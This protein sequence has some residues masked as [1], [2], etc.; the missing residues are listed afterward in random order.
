MQDFSYYW[1]FIVSVGSFA[2]VC[3]VLLR[4][5]LRLVRRDPKEK[6]AEDVR[7]R[8]RILR[9]FLLAVTLALTTLTTLSAQ[10]F[11]VT[12]SNTVPVRDSAEHF[13]QIKRAALH[14]AT[15]RILIPA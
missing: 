7:T 12:E 14:T 9:V 3:A 5:Y 15:A 2:C 13:F 1:H 10:T 11:L 6:D 4:L 8:G